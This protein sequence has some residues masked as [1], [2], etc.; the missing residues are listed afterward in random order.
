M[1]NLIVF[2]QKSLKALAVMIVGN[3]LVQK[4]VLDME[5]LQLVGNEIVQRQHQ[6][7]DFLMNRLSAQFQ[8]ECTLTIFAEIEAVLILSILSL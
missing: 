4:I 3:G 5:I 6:R 1:T 8:T 7:T 2:G